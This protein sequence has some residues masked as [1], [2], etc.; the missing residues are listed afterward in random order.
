MPGH[1]IVRADTTR[2]TLS[3][4]S[5]AA[6]R[7]CIAALTLAVLPNAL[8]ANTYLFSFTAQDLLNALGSQQPSSDPQS[9]Y[10]A[11]FLQPQL[12]SLSYDAVNTPTANTP[13]QT[14]TTST[15]TDFSS[16]GTGTWAEYT[17]GQ[18]Q[19]TVEILSNTVAYNGYDSFIG[20]SYSDTL[21]WPEGWGTVSGVI[22]SAYNGNEIFNFMIET[23]QILTTSV[24]VNGLASAL[25]SNSSFS[26]VS[27]KTAE[28]ISFTLSEIP[29]YIPEPANWVLMVTGLALMVASRRYIF[30]PQFKNRRLK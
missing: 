12:L 1:S 28:N 10:F 21:A 4:W 19:A 23:S 5:G 7:F 15:I 2:R 25:E 30:K 16:S 26:Y 3:V 14:W 27:P 11:I 13:G 29:T 8:H 17:K 24:T 6:L 18:T 9:A 22:Q 20:H